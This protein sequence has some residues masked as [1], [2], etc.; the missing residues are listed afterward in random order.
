MFL[1]LLPKGVDTINHFLDQ[2]NLRV[3]EPVL[4]G[5]VVGVASLSAKL[6]TGAAGLQV[7]LLTVLCY[8]LLINMDRG[9]HTG[10][11]VRRVEVEV[12]ILLINAKVLAGQ[13]HQ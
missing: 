3:S 4:V 5:D 7:K 6:T 1:K 10:T 11:K 13:N 8:K 2:L 9:P 12:S